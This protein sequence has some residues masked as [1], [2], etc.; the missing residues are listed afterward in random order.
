MKPKPALTH[1]KPLPCV[2]GPL[3][4]QK[5]ATTILFPF[6]GGGATSQGFSEGG[7]YYVRVKDKWV[8]A[9]KG[10]P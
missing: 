8:H 10:K 7:E 9:K 4:G 1:G 5:R 2:G 6:L 3:D